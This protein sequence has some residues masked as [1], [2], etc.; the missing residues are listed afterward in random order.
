VFPTRDRGAPTRQRVQGTAVT[1]LRK[2]ETGL[3]RTGTKDDRTRPG[4]VADGWRGSREPAKASQLF[5]GA[6]PPASPVARTR[7]AQSPPRRRLPRRAGGGGGSPGPGPS[8]RAPQP[9]G[10]GNRR[11]ESSLAFKLCRN[12]LSPLPTL[13]PDARRL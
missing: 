6:S 2:Q 8:C 11:W 7:L 5:P 3:G 4:G 12:N 13:R 9:R 10:S 1:E